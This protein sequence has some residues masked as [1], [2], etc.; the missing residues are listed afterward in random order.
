VSERVVAFLPAA[1]EREVRSTLD[2]ARI[3]DITS[4]GWLN[5]NDPDPEF[6][7]HAMW[8][9]GQPS[10]DHS[11]LLGDQPVRRRPEEIERLILTAGEDFCGV[12][13]ISRLSIGLA[14]LWHRQARANPF[15]ESPFFWLHHTDA[16]LKLAIA[17]N[18]LRDLLVVACT[19]TSADSY[20]SA[21]KRNRRYVTPFAEAQRLLAGR[22]LVDSRVSEALASLPKFG[23]D[24]FEYVDRRNAIV[25]EVSTHMA[26]SIGSSFSELQKRFDQEQEA[27]FSRKSGDLVDWT[28]Q[29]DERLRELQTQIDRAIAD[30]RNWHELL[31][32]SSNCVFQIEHWSRFLG[33]Q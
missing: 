15:S 28:K 20:K 23:D 18:R 6:I 27:G 7:G 1:L 31:I 21:A 26:E 16:F 17:S 5:E 3:Y 19:G 11:A 30:L 12:M 24:I 33:R 32:R 13:Q 8:Q 4:Y 2:D 29:A 22:G 10:I 25:H 9:L 14:L